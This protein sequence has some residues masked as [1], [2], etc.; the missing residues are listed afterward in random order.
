VPDD[1]EMRYAIKQ[2]VQRVSGGSLDQIPPMRD[3]GME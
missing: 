1:P 3:P 2:Q